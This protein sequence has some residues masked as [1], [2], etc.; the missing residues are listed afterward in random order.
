MDEGFEGI[1]D[2]SHLAAIL[3][4][5]AEGVFVLDRKSR[6]ILWNK[7]MVELTGRTAESIIGRDCKAV[8]RLCGS[9]DH[10]E[11]C[12]LLLSGDVEG[13]ECVL[14]DS[15]GGRIPVIRNSRILY[16][17]SGSPKGAVAT[18]ADLRPQRRVQVA[19]ELT[20]NNW[21]K[22]F[23]D[24]N[25]NRPLIGE[26]EGMRKLSARLIKAAETDVTILIEGET[27]TGK[28]IV[29]RTAH[30]ASPRYK[31]PFVSVNCS[32]LS[33][34]LLE[35]ELF[36]HVKGAFTGAVE[37]RI[38]RFEAAEGGTLFLDE[39][40]EMDSSVQVKLLRVLQERSIERLGSSRSKSVD[41][42]VVAA[43]N[44]SLSSLVETGL[45]RKDLYYRLKVF[46]LKTIPLR[47]RK[48]DIPLLIKHFL[49]LFSRNKELGLEKRFSRAAWN[50]I[51][52]HSW[53]GNVRELENTIRHGLILSGDEVIE[54]RHLPEALVSILKSSDKVPASM[55]KI[56][57]SRLSREEMT[58]LLEECRGN[59]SEVARRLGVHRSTVL[60]HVRRLK[61]SQ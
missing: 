6:V 21:E 1:L 47:E 8:G 40:A 11:H 30:R 54:R 26:S 5:M 45:F 49:S 46:T 29:A 22:T 13:Q 48:S 15:N 9:E 23:T 10:K 37:D 55:R 35:S 17:E 25:H 53:P 56:Q 3:D 51:M 34:G 38:G 33:S 32:T 60:R 39:V 2:G 19:L 20:R 16:D 4:T 18:L 14:R 43:S 59:L 12:A 24:H 31:G 58:S 7:K 42:R 61:I 52:N 28:E 44:K 27:G 36:G 50:A 57:T 41:V